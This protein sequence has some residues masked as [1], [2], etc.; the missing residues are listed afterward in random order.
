MSLLLFV[1]NPSKSQLFTNI[2]NLVII[3]QYYPI[4][5]LLSLKSSLYLENKNLKEKILL[6]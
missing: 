5:N 6:L 4:L 3:N 1:L 2:N